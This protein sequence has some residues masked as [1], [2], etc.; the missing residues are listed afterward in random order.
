MQVGD[1]AK[2]RNTGSVGK[3]EDIMEEEGRTW[4]LL[5][6]TRLYY[7][8]SSLEP[9]RPEEYRKESEGDRDLKDQL[10][11]VDR[12]RDQIADMQEAVSRITPSGAG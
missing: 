7:D 1:L 6:T 9:A 11:E 8:V 2:Y 4:A 5:D 12:I 3:V 10:R